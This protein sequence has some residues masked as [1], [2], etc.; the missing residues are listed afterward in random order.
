M[1]VRASSSTLVLWA[2]FLWYFLIFPMTFQP[3]SSQD[4][5]AWKTSLSHRSAS[6][7]TLLVWLSV[8]WMWVVRHAGPCRP[9]QERA[10]PD[11]SRHAV[12]PGAT[13]CL[14]DRRCC[15]LK[16]LFRNRNLMHRSS[17]RLGKGS[18]MT[19]QMGKGLMQTLHHFQ[20]NANFY[21]C[22]ALLVLDWLSEIYAISQSSNPYSACILWVN[23]LLI[24]VAK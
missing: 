20:M 24:M 1:Q 23:K 14:F 2:V 18:L 9:R 16:V 21:S 4:Y 7:C 5:E 15:T 11:G 12:Y 19:S 17:T 13:K 3:V 22:K 8:V 6:L 10:T